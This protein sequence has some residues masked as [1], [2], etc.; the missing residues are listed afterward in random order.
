[1]AVGSGTSKSF[2]FRAEQGE[3][4]PTVVVRDVEVKPDAASPQAAQEIVRLL[5][6]VPG[7]EV[8]TDKEIGTSRIFFSFR[9][10]DLFAQ[11]REKLNRLRAKGIEPFGGAFDT[12][13]SIGE[14]RARF[15]EGETVRAAGRVTAHR[16]MGKSMI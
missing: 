10:N 11:R 13:G 6:S 2:R 15:K 1:M 8:R 7:F 14:I 12:S 5:T 16:D 9:L 4:P 3:P